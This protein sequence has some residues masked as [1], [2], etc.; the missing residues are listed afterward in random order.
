VFRSLVD[1]TTTNLSRL[2]IH[3]TTLAPGQSPHPPHRHAHEELMIVRRG[4]L[5][6]LQNGV[7]R[8]AHSGDVIFEASQE[9]HG[10]RNE[11]SDSATYLVIRLDP[12]DIASSDS[13]RCVASR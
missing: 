1:T 2:E 9:L 13:A 6:V 7:T 8:H 12:H 4:S 3:L 5:A 10:L 11:G